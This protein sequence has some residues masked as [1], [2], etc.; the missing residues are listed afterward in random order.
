MLPEPQRIKKRYI[1]R[2]SVFVLQSPQDLLHESVRPT[3]LIKSVGAEH[4]WRLK[5]TSLPRD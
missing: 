5:S 3:A 4:I 2:V 1:T